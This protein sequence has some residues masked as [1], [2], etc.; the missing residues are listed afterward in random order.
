MV[1]QY[2]IIQK[3]II[4]TGLSWWHYSHTII[5][6]EIW[7]LIPLTNQALNNQPTML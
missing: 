2:N 7:G 4:T 5:I 1:V 3:I 6:T